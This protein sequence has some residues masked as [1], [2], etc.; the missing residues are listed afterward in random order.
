MSPPSWREYLSSLFCNLIIIN[1]G[2]WQKSID[3]L[4]NWT[5]HS[6][7]FGSVG[8]IGLGFIFIGRAH[9]P[10]IP[11]AEMNQVERPIQRGI[12]LGKAM[13][14]VP[15]PGASWE[16]EPGTWTGAATIL[17][18]S[19]CWYFFGLAFGFVGFYCLFVK[20]WEE[21]LCATKFEWK[22]QPCLAAALPW[23]PVDTNCKPNYQ[24]NASQMPAICKPNASQY[25][26]NYKVNCQ[27][28]CD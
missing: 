15:E 12:S 10:N 13:D 16:L 28:N 20:A 25:K 6:T 3:G 7:L 1:L 24:P 27:V 26:L 21:E 5:G 19:S 14:W 18:L 8:F 4:F 11:Q 23:S 22:R 9:L 17:A 2:A